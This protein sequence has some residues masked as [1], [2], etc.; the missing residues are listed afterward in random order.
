MKEEK[1]A[2]PMVTEKHECKQ[3]RDLVLIIEDARVDI[4]RL[5]KAVEFHRRDAEEAKMLLKAAR[6]AEEAQI[7]R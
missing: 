7:A 4:E 3:S 6:T 2:L 1:V 5:T